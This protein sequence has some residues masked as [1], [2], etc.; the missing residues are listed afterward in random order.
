MDD[1][2][3]ETMVRDE[4]ARARAKFPGQNVYKLLAAA[5]EELGETSQA[6]LKGEGAQRIREEACQVAA[7]AFRIALDCD[8]S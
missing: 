1:T 7:M 5:M 2:A 8:I 3:F 4:L 6:T